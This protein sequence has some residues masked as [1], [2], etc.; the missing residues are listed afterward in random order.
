M[1]ITKLLVL[2]IDKY[3][4]KIMDK[5]SDETISDKNIMKKVFLVGCLEGIVD[6][7]LIVGAIQT[8]KAITGTIKWI[9]KK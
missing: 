9:I 4:K 3:D 6:G 2:K 5:I 8:V 1:W 7:C